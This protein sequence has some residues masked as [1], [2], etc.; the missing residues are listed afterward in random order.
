LLRSPFRWRNKR[1][2]GASLLGALG[3]ALPRREGRP[4]AITLKV[5]FE[6]GREETIRDYDGLHEAV[7][8]ALDLANTHGKDP[9]DGGG[10]PEQLRV[11]RGE[12][13]ELCVRVIRGG[14]IGPHH[15]ESSDK[16]SSHESRH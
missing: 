15:D 13:M 11:Y 10:P 6:D 12:V 14:L 7:I 1:T 2:P 4:V 5:V 8:D 9:G 3:I 16:T